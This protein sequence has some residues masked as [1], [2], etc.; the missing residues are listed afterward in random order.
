MRNINREYLIIRLMTFF[1]YFGDCLFYGY[2][3]LFLKSRNLLE[4]QIGAICAITPI[5]SLL[6]NPFWNVLSKNANTNRNIMRVIT[7][8][9]GIFIILYTKCYSLEMIALITC[10]VAM[11]GS[12]FYSL[13]D[14]FCGTYAEV[15]QKNYTK[16]RFIGTFA[17]FCGT[18]AAA[19]VL[20]LM[21]NN[22]S[23]LLVLGGVIFISVSVWFFFIKPIDLKLISDSSEIKRDYKAVLKNKVF[24]FYMF[25]Y[26]ILI[27]IPYSTDSYVGLYFTEHKDIDS[28]IWSLVFGSVILVEFFI[29]LFL[30]KHG[31]RFDNTKLFFIAGLAYSFRAIILAFNPPLPL[32]IMGALFRGIG[33]GFFVHVNIRLIKRICG[34]ENVT[35]GLFI[36]AIGVALVQTI[37]SYVFGNLVQLL[38]YPMFFGIIAIIGLLGNV[39]HFIYLKTNGFS[40]K[41]C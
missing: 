2:F 9:E 22:Y 13:H 25:I 17:Y 33:Y 15:Y 40:Y 23:L 28:S 4:S 21:P 10:L 14:G 24:W 29:L 27:T 5:V 6:C 26:F 30:S 39:I 32:L 7:I 18:I 12:P 8:L 3:Y 34:I 1:R 19:L 31:D 41:S 35:A 16:I 37:S 36:L 20:R 11:V 38:G